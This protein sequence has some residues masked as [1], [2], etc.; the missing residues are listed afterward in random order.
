M[1]TP[2]ITLDIAIRLM[3]I[4]FHRLETTHAVKATVAFETRVSTAW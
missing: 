4:A 1:A 2:P 3:L